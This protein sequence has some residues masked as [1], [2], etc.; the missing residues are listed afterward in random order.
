M[1]ECS[2]H[3]TSASTTMELQL[4]PRQDLVTS[5]VSNGRMNTRSQAIPKSGAAEHRR[6]VTGASRPDNPS[7]IKPLYSERKHPRNTVFQD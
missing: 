3:G 7:Q 5:R 1:G 4:R 6:T 2:R